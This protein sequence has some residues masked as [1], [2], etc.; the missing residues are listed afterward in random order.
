VVALG[1]FGP[2]DA[3]DVTKGDA[4]PEHRRRFE[5]PEGFR[6]TDEHSRHVIVGWE[7]DR[8]LGKR[9]VFAVRDAGTGAL[10]GGCELLP[11]RDGVANVSYWTYPEHR[12]RGVA[13]R[14]LALISEIARLELG[15]RLVEL[16]TD[17]DNIPSQRIAASADFRPA[18]DRDGRLLYVRELSG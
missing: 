8:R 13:T 3:P 16:V 15:I 6:P 11:L 10:L 2:S 7:R 12:R 18:G 1:Y 14:A 17:A 4:D 9:F 5:F